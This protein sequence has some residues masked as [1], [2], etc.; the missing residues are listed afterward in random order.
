M[1][2]SLA[3]STLFPTFIMVPIVTFPAINYFL[4]KIAMT[5]SAIRTKII[6]IVLTRDFTEKFSLCKNGS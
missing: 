6:S 4:I 3:N 5:L 2:R 1:Y